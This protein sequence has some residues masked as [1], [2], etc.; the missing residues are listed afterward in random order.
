MHQT[1]EGVIEVDETVRLL[2]PVEGGR[3]R[4]VPVTVLD[5]A[6]EVVG[7]DLAHLTERAQS[8]W[9]L[10]EEEEAWRDLKPD[11]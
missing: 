6:P 2:E 8:D 4:R 7:N 10:D 9:L 3:V 11:Q 5:E 1:I